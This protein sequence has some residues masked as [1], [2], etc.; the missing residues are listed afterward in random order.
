[1]QCPDPNLVVLQEGSR[2]KHGDHVSANRLAAS[3]DHHLHCGL[4]SDTNAIR[5]SARVLARTWE[6]PRDLA[7][8]AFPQQY[9]QG[10]ECYDNL[11]CVYEPSSA[12][13]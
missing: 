13:L 8:S 1:M 12:P 7:Q 2:S 3:S 10:C 4:L 9:N 11:S 6:G 5:S